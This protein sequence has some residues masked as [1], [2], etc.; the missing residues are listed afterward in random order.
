M[1]YT[2][3]LNPAIDY[4]VSLEAFYTGKVNR[5]QSDYKEAGGKGIN[6]SRVLDRFGIPSTA[7]GFVG[8]FTGKFIK[9]YLTEMEIEHDFVS[10]KQDTR[11]N[12]KLKAEAEESEVNGVSPTIEEEEY[13]AFLSKLEQL[14]QGDIVI[15]AG[16]LP[17]SLST[18]VYQE[19]VAMLKQKGIIAILDTSGAPL[20]EAIKASPTFIK[21]NH[22]ELAELFET[23]VKDDQDVVR[24]AKQL[25]QEQQIDHVLVS[26]AKAGAIYVG[27]GGV[28]KLSA[29][30]GTAVHSVGAGDSAVAGFIY[31]WQTSK[32]AEEAAKY[33]VAAGSATAFSKTLC[34]KEEV[35]ALLPQ[36]NVT[37]I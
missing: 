32:N 3:T 11:I 22:H 7:L 13:Q 30:K 9:D 2:V 19:M 4:V 33:A 31:S 35:E 6:V 27:A 25:H 16:S 24:L 36:V 14:K 15:L 28:L 29:P 12:V 20:A 21:P 34:T 26:M 17:S 37:D 18:N 5:S 8:G 1:I 10:L 23:E